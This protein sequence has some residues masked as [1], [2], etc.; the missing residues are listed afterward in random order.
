[1]A[2]TVR[3]MTER[4]PVPALLVL[5]CAGLAPASALAET[6]RLDPAAS[7][8][9]TWTSNA[10]F[11]EGPARRDTILELRP[12][13]AI[14]GEGARLRINGSAALNGVA[15]ARDTQDSEVL[16]RVDLNA[17]LEAIERLFFIEAGYRASQTS[18]NPFG[19]RPDVASLANT[20]TTTEAR[21][22][23]YIEGAAGAN[24][25]YRVRSDNSWVREI[26]AEA[27]T[28]AAAGYFG[29]HSA[30][31]ERDPQPFGW[32]LQA[33]RNDTR[34]DD[35]VQPS[36][37]LDE[38][39]AVLT[40]AFG[41]TLTAGVRAGHERNNFETEVRS[42]GFYGAEA[43]WR[44][45]PRT[46]LDMF[47]ENRFFG[48]GYRLG[49]NH[50]M[51]RLAWRV[52][53]SRGIDTTP[54]SLFELPATQ[55]V[56][57]LL[58]AMFT[59]RFPDPIERARAVQD[60][61]AQRGLPTSTLQPTSLVDERVSVVT[62]RETGMTLTGVRNTLSFSLFHVTTEDATPASPLATGSALNNNV[63][64]GVS[65]AVTHR[66]GV[67]TSLSVSA[68]W[69]RIR[70]LGVAG[71]DETSQQGVTLQV[72]L[73]AAPKTSA[74]FG[75]RYRKLDSNVAVEGREG[76]LFVGMDHRF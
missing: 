51:P 13:I 54:Q 7:A 37:T 25:R 31:I 16:P 62:R 14:R 5:A 23:P 39:R 12:S 19:A 8:Q 47:G 64:R 71:D 70:A 20:L 27:A 48:T 28:S 34:Y 42:R 6:W 63:Q 68:D 56:T 18:E 11:G 57:A 9:L 69:S 59:T 29:R 2:T 65:M 60:F 32:R 75:G 66:L 21:F 52:L 44:P 55:N 49:F 15:Y 53:L 45:T 40:Y 3:R 26:G 67:S 36:L 72:N 50:R 22:T 43:T 1:M 38:A 73:Q 41:E 17:R 46:T 61:I 35:S 74:F 10:N 33:E 24:L 4:A 58:D 76:A 30:S